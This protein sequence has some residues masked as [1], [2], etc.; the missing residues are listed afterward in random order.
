MEPRWI[1]IG[2][3]AAAH[4]SKGE[5][6]VIPHT[7]FPERFLNME[8]VQL[9][10]ESDAEPALSFTVERARLHK[11]FVL[12]KL[13]GVDN[14]GQAQTLKGMLIKV[15]S[16]DVVP[17]PPGRHYIFQL[18]GLKV[19]TTEGL[20]LG[21]ITD[22][23][24]TGANDVYVIDPNPGV[25]KQREILIPVIEPVVLDVNLETGVVLVNLLDG[26]LD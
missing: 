13:A 24:Q 1:L 17:L 15:D 20:E 11:Q 8:R 4:S 23:L 3:I 10:K 14:I 5:V 9:F 7:E 2:E 6:R 19:I 21:V 22:L 18:I 12:L 16:R 26:L 25:T